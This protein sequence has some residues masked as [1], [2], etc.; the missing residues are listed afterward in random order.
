MAFD[1]TVFL[2]PVDG[3]GMLRCVRGQNRRGAAC[4]RE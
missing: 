3:N 1:P 4:K 2:N